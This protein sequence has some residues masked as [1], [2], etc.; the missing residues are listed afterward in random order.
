MGVQNQKLKCLNPQ[1][2]PNPKPHPATAALGF[3]PQHPPGDLPTTAA[4]AAKA[5][6][7]MVVVVHATGTILQVMTSLTIVAV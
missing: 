6:V 7:P 2:P 4:A 1:A 3:D 5:R